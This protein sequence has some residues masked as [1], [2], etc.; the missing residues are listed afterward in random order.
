MGDSRSRVTSFQ[1]SL[2]SALSMAVHFGNWRDRYC[3]TS[4]RSRYLRGQQ[5]VPHVLDA[6]VGGN[7]R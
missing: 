7:G 1:P 2:S 4:S 6:I 5:A 3:T